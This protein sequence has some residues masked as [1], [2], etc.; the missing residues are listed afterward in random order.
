[1]AEFGPALE[2]IVGQEGGYRKVTVVGDPGGETYAG[3]SRRKNPKWAGW[4]AIDAGDQG[5]PRLRKL[6][7]E[8]YRSDYWNRLKLPPDMEQRYANM[9][10]SAAVNVGVVHARL[11][12][13]D[14]RGD[15]ITFA[16]YWL[17]YYADLVHDKP[18]LKRF[19]HGWFR[20]VLS[21]V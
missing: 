20:R 18:E 3:I 5:S 7:Y 10:F 12:F 19:Q 14:S 2:A 16:I 15:R 8:L 9:I 11:L 1:M 6:V 4:R 21:L 17:S 13:Q